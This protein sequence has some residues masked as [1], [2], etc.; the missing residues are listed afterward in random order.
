MPESVFQRY[1]EKS[2]PYR[3]EGTIQVSTLMAGI[4]ADEHKAEAWLKS[5]VLDPDK[6]T[7][8]MR[9]VAETMAELGI[10]K[11]AALQRVNDLRNL[12]AFRRDSKGLYIAG[13]H[14]KAALKESVSIAI[15]SRKIDVKGWGETKKW[16]TN[17]F[18]EH[19]FV[20]EDKLRLGKTEPDGIHQSFP[21]SRFG[22]SIQ[23][24]EY[25]LDTDISFTVET[26]FEFTEDFWAMLWTTGERNG[27]GAMRSQ[28]YG[29]YV[30][31]KWEPVRNVVPAQKQ[32]KIKVRPTPGG[33]A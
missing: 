32:P 33:N 1:Q 17:F 24:N 4:P 7:G 6:D 26:D 18:P 30:V 13:A 31:T 15:A 20:I 3:F 14:L 19:V 21:K 25:V 29:T 12:C 27:L 5:R 8:L 11:D 28:G 16:I 2:W 10:D 23:Y 9:A 22:S